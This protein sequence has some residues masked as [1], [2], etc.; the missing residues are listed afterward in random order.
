MTIGCGLA[1]VG[2]KWRPLSNSR[3]FGEGMSWVYSYRKGNKMLNYLLADILFTHVL[4][5]AA[6]KARGMV[7]LVLRRKWL[8]T[9]F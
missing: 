3:P 9:E 2:S 6:V 5:F 1:V 8:Y 7:R 4:R